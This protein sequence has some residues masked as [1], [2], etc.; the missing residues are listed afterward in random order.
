M[1]PLEAKGCTLGGYE[2][3]AVLLGWELTKK[4]NYVDFTRKIVNSIINTSSWWIQDLPHYG[5]FEEVN[6]ITK[7]EGN[8]V[9]CTLRAG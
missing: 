3:S 4:C 2:M 8:L 1:R 9:F 5:K 7:N 6:V